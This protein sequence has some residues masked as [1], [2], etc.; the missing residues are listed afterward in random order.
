METNDKDISPAEQE[1]RILLESRILMDLP[2]IEDTQ[3]KYHPLRKEH[4]CCFSKGN[5]SRTIFFSCEKL[6]DICENP[7]CIEDVT[8]EAIA[9]LKRRIL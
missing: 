8:K 1:G 2:D 4:S 5:K 6:K 3:W 7:D 9:E